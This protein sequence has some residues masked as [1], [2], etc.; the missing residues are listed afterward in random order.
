MFKRM[1]VM[2]AAL[3]AAAAVQAQGS[4]PDT[5]QQLRRAL[6]VAAYEQEVAAILA[7]KQQEQ[8]EVTERKGLMGWIKKLIQKITNR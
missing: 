7:A 8:R 1:I 5:E 2:A 6:Q 3:V 4:L